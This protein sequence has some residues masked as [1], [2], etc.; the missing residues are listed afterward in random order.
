MG[1]ADLHI[2]T[3]Y[4]EDGFSSVAEIFKRAKE[5]KL[6]V[7]AITD[8]NNIKAIKEAKKISSYFNVGFVAGE[9]IDVK[10]GDLIALFIEEE[11]KEGRS[12]FDTIREIHQQGGL[13]I[14]PHP[15]NW[16]PGGIKFKDIL[17]I[18]ENLDGIELLNGAWFGWLKSKE[19]RK[20]NETTFKLAEFGGSDSH[21]AS[22]VGTAYTNFEGSSVFDLYSSIKNKKTSFGGGYWSYKQRILWLG[23]YLK[24][25]P[26]SPFSILYKFLKNSFTV[27]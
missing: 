13:A 25:F 1:R 14:V 4:S 10:E 12:A 5:K 16:I 20:L 8:H 9:E 7:I 21:L 11:I 19:S 24:R 6:D 22:Q 2:H 27:L 26:N 3:Y 15:E 23:H 18:Y 17:K